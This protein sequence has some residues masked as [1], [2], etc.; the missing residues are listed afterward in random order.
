MK[1]IL[2]LLLTALMV[3]GASDAMAQKKSSTT[4]SKSKAKTTAEAPATLGEPIK[5]IIE[6]NQGVISDIQKLERE[7]PSVVY[8]VLKTRAFMGPAVQIAS[9]NSDYRL[10]NADKKA[11]IQ[12]FNQVLDATK[13]GL[14]KA[15]YK[16][17][18][19]N[20]M[21][22]DMKSVMASEINKLVI[23]RGFYM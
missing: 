3:I 21:I 10:T 22:S 2:A 20:K 4:R 8:Q 18:N 13:P 11:L 9:E 19:V 16:Q 7:S 14:V 1:R 5:Q 12:S 6:E 17:A 23:L 15:G